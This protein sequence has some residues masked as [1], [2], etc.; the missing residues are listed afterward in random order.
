[1]PFA[2]VTIG[3]L[4]IVTGARDTYSDAGKLFVSELTGPNNFTYWLLAF[5]AL[6]SLGYNETLRPFARGFMVL[7]FLSMVL[8]NRG[9][10]DQFG[11]A[12]KQG[13]STGSGNQPK[14]FGSFAFN[15]APFDKFKNAVDS[16]GKLTA[17]FGLAA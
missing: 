13:P 9:V 8:R 11:K 14:I 16:F 7:I 5:G 15:T 4:L 6:G 3:L 10:F 12:I 2:L 1:M 17:G